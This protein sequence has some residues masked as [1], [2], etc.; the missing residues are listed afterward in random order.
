[1]LFR[2]W[3]EELPESTVIFIRQFYTTHT[4]Y[5][6]VPEDAGAEVASP[7]PDPRPTENA[8]AGGGGVIKELT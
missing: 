2:F 4:T 7:P 1:M 3:A 5:G 6:A 8:F